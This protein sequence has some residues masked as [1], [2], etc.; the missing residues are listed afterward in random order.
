[1]LKDTNLTAYPYIDMLC[2]CACVCV[3]WLAYMTFS[4]YTIGARDFSCM[5]PRD[6]DRKIPK[7]QSQ[8]MLYVMVVTNT[9]S[10]EETQL[11]KPPPTTM[12]NFTSIAFC[13][14][15]RRFTRLLL[16]YL[17][18]RIQTQCSQMLLKLQ[19]NCWT[20]VKCWLRTTVLVR[21]AREL[22]VCGFS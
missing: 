14:S 1:M 19:P 5:L 10:A 7:K 15:I 16:I 12:S 9:E 11:Q 3:Q 4:E 18:I 6:T 2:S 22:N 8:Q 17:P 13:S 20:T 21:A